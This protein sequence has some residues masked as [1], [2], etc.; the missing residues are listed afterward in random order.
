MPA[1]MQDEATRMRGGTTEG[2]VLKCK[3][4]ES[5]IGGRIG[6][7]SGEIGEGAMMWELVIIKR[8]AQRQNQRTVKW[9]RS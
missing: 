8:S 2:D 5:G 9:Q 1:V 4:V 6:Y 3:T 7:C